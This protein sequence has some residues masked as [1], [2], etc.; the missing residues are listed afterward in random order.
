ME[1]TVATRDPLLALE[2]RVFE[3]PQTGARAPLASGVGCVIAAHAD[4]HVEGADVL[5]R[6]ES[7]APARVR[8][9]VDLRD[10]LLEVLEGEVHLGEQTLTAG[11]QAPWAM[12]M[13]LRIGRSVVAFGRAALPNWPL[14]VTG[15]SAAPADHQTQISVAAKPRRT[16]LTR[17]A[18]FWLAIVGGSVLAI[19]GAALATAHFAIEPTATEPVEVTPLAVLLKGSEFSTL[20]TTTRKDGRV[21]VTGRLATLA[22]RT[23]LDA[24][25]TERQVAATVEVQVDET[26]ARD[27]TETFRI[28]GVAVRARVDGKGIVAVEAAERQPDRLARAEEVVRRD[29]R[30]LEKMTVTNTATPLPKPLPPVSDDPG[31]RIVSLVPGDPAYIVTAD[32]SRYFVGSILPT[33]HR[34][35]AVGEHSVSLEHDG[36]QTTLN[37]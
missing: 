24:W 35:A 37:F 3:G 23:R 17:R 28:N 19:C 1:N 10:A 22:E 36:Q 5:L 34:I 15:S 14:A 18:E 12:H 27:V 33:G 16:P 31:K 8:V 11:S 9:T 21:E 26:L 4:G 30:G 2:L 6:E 7:G 13:R 32:G 20:S 25:L 29:V